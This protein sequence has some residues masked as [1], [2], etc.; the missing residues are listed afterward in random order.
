MLIWGHIAPSWLFFVRKIYAYNDFSGFVKIYF[1]FKR[2]W[3]PVIYDPESKSTTE[4]D[5][6][7]LFSSSL[8]SLTDTLE[9][10]LT[11]ST[12]SI[13]SESGHFDPSDPKP[14]EVE[15]DQQ[16]VLDKEVL[17]GIFV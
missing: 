9:K 1:T 6:F 13:R 4:T 11:N 10:T 16:E 12:Q 17:V 8:K 2:S 3:T 14:V 5:E 15:N 7:S